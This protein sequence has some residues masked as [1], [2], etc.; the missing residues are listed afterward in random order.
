MS[1]ESYSRCWLQTLYFFL[2]ARRTNCLWFLKT[3]HAWNKH[4]SDQWT[5]FDTVSVHF[6][7]QLGREVLCVFGCCWYMTCASY[8]S[9]ETC[10]R[11]C[12]DELF[13]DNGFIPKCSQADILIY[14][15]K[16][17]SSISW[18]VINASFAI[19]GL[20]MQRRLEEVSVSSLVSRSLLKWQ[21]I[22][23]P[24]LPK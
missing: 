17:T 9:V 1:Y 24:S 4:A 13:T 12:S 7:S 20:K 8:C 16:T 14:I 11:K 10:I 18:H 3:E 19:K 2:S 21:K 6:R 22:S 15:Y 23:V 5:L